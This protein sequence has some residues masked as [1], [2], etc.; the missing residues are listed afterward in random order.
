MRLPHK[1]NIFVTGP[2]D[3]VHRHYH[4]IVSY[5]MNARLTGALE[6]IKDR[7]YHKI[8]DAGCGGG[9]FLPELSLLCDNLF[10][11]D[12]HE[13]LY[14]VESMSRKEGLA[15]R[16]FKADVT[17]LPFHDNEFDC[18]TCI[19][20][21]EFVKDLDKAFAELNRVVKAGGRVVIGFPVENIITDIAF[22]AIG[23]NAR[24]AHSVNQADIID[25]AKKKFAIERTVTFPL[26]INMKFALFAHCSLIKK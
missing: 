26:N 22:F 5:F 24:R 1:R 25:A 23:I 13:N 17:A 21:L 8:L 11:S 3:P 2:T 10:A 15:V 19:S 18:V 9:I 7:R 14:A 20:V 4:P 12:I 6:L 16:F